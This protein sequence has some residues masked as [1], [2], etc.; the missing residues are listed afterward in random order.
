MGAVLRSN[1]NND[2]SIRSVVSA[3]VS[4]NKRRVFIF[5]FGVF[6]LIEELENC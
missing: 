6:F 1:N 2:N 4:C 5:P 3:S